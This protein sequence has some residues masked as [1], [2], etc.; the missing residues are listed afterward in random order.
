MAEKTIQELRAIEKKYEEEK[1]ARQRATNAKL[2]QEAIDAKEAQRSAPKTPVAEAPKAEAP[3]PPVAPVQK[4]Q[5]G[6]IR[7]YSGGP[8]MPDD[9]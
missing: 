6:G 3:K 5:P 8:V 9:L 4:K 1:L 7:G 2:R